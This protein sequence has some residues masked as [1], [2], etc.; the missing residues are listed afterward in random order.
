MGYLFLFISVLAGASKGFCGKKVSGFVETYKDTMLC[1]FL[2]MFFCIAIGLGMIAFEGDL[3]LLAI[4]RDMLLTTLLSGVSTAAFVILWIISVKDGSY[5]VLD[6]FLMLGVIFT[7]VLCKI[8]FN[9][10]I[11]LNQYLGFALLVA[12]TL[13]MCWYNIS[14]RGKMTLKS[15]LLL[16]GCGVAN[17]LTDFSQKLFVYNQINST[18]AVF[19]FYTYVFAAVTLG[20]AFVCF[21]DNTGED[22]GKHNVSFIKNIIGYIIVM[23]ICLFA[24]SFFKVLAA[25]YLD[26]AKLYPLTQGSAL[27]LSVLMAGVFFK[28]KI[29]VKCIIGM[30]MAFGALLIINVL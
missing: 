1:N 13:V 8:F 19:N 17:G 3:S 4:N 14:S 20:I 16:V 10:A 22:S 18:N 6:V 27:I 29:T 21:K 11:R 9:E 25:G 23:A 26:S 2:R 28:E 15:L 30:I 5:V 7:T 12:A 24:N